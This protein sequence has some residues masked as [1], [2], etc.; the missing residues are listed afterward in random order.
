MVEASER[1]AAGA[2]RLVPTQVC[3]R[4]VA[5]QPSTCSNWIRQ[6]IANGTL[7]L[8][9]KPS[10]LRSVQVEQITV[11]TTVSIMLRRMPR[12]CRKPLHR[13]TGSWKPFWKPDDD[14]RRRQRWTRSNSGTA[15]CNSRSHSIAWP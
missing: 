4:L 15:F 8:I 7:Q 11:V 1:Y 2:R 13:R 14:V 12:R 9:E 6:C 3:M 10:N 5:G